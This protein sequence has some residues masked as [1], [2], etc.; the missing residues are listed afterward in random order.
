MQEKLENFVIYF[1][2]LIRYFLINKRYQ[3]LKFAL[4]SPFAHP[5]F[6]KKSDR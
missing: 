4:I 5:V 3:D 2:I 1:L 6:I